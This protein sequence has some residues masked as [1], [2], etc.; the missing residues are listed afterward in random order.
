[1]GDGGLESLADAAHVGAVDFGI[2]LNYPFPYNARCSHARGFP[3]R[4]Y[5]GAGHAW[6]VSDCYYHSDVAGAWY[7]GRRRRRIRTHVVVRTRFVVGALR[8]RV[9][10]SRSRRVRTL[11]NHNLSDAFPATS[12]SGSRK[13]HSRSPIK[14]RAYY[15]V[16]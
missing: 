15:L 3:R 9:R 16:P 14:Q 8:C 2:G 13:L 12:K 1:M 11:D 5:E 10:F 6:T 7:A 4:S